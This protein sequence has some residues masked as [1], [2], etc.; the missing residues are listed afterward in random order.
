M[1]RLGG[2][3]SSHRG[4]ADAQ[5]LDGRLDLGGPLPEIS[6][7]VFGGR[8][9]VAGQGNQDREGPQWSVEEIGPEE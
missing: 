6:K 7:G 9:D 2:D 8:R 1:R 5:S 3:G 4:G